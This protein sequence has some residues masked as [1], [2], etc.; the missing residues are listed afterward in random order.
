[1][2]F[3]LCRSITQK[4]QILYL[5]PTTFIMKTLLL[6]TIS[7]NLLCVNLFGTSSQKSGD[8]PK[9]ISKYGKRYDLGRYPRRSTGEPKKIKSV[10]G[11]LIGGTIGAIIGSEIGKKQRTTG[12]PKRVTTHSYTL[13]PKQIPLRSKNASFNYLL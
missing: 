9:T 10:E 12:N 4:N 7:L 11:I 1:M 5:K 3:I 6:L 13:H 2:I 8:W